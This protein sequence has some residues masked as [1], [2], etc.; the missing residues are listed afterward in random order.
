[1]SRA[2]RSASKELPFVTVAL[3]RRHGWER[4]EGIGMT[5]VREIVEAMDGGIEIA[6]RLGHRTT[7]TL[8][9]CEVLDSARRPATR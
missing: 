2:T 7:V 5:L 6:S 4:D 9:F 8:W 3:V 1:M